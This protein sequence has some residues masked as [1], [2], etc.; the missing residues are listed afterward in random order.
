MTCISRTTRV[1]AIEELKSTDQILKI[2]KENLVSAQGRMKQM[3]NLHTTE[4]EFSVGDWVFLLVI[5]I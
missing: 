1:Q 5:T 2:L 3:P 4:L